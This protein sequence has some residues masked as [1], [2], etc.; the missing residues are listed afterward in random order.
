MGHCVRICLSIKGRSTL[1]N[2]L[3]LIYPSSDK[4]KSTALSSAYK[5]RHTLSGVEVYMRTSYVNDKG[6]LLEK[7]LIDRLSD[8][9]VALVFVF[10]DTSDI[11]DVYKQAIDIAFTGSLVEGTLIIPVLVEG[12][13]KFSNFPKLSLFKTLSLSGLGGL[14]WIEELKQLIA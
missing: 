9:S 13:L 6:R 7:K 4:A 14:G 12:K 5:L 11:D 3:V 1:R 10:D 2:K 8:D